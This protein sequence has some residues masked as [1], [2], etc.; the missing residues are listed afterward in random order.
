[1]VLETVADFLARYEV[2]GGIVVGLSGGADSVCLVY[3]LKHLGCAVTAVHVN[4][5]IRGAEAQRDAEAARAFCQTID[6]PFVLCTADAPQVAKVQ[7]LTLEQAARA[8]RYEALSQVQKAKQAQYIAVAHNLNDQAETVLLRLARG[9]GLTGLT[10]MKPVRG[11]IL[12]PLLT[13]PRK[14][15]EAFCA[16]HA[17]SYVT[18]S[19]NADP[20]YA[21]NAVRSRVLPALDAIHPESAA[22]I[23]RCATLLATDADYLAHAARNAFDGIA[24]VQPQRVALSIPALKALHCALRGRVLRMAI[25]HSM[26]FTAPKVAAATM[27]ET[28][29]AAKT[30]TTAQTTVSLTM[31]SSPTDIAQV[32]IE[33]CY[34]LCDLQSGRILCLPGGIRV[35]KSGTELIF[36]HA[37]D[38][39]QAQTQPEMVWFSLG[40][41]QMG[42]QLL[43]ISKVDQMG[44]RL[45]ATEYLYL[46]D[47]RGVC[48]RHKQSGD[49]IT[50]LGAPG[51][52][53]LK[54]YLIDKK[55]PLQQRGQLV[56]VARGHEILAVLGVT[57]AQCAA[58]TDGCNDIY[59]LALLN[60]PI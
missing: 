37:H 55:I 11:Q 45:P 22:N 8:V 24:H 59:K 7:G 29:T 21:R 42:N 1:M 10:A 13:V 14:E 39:A 38:T 49:Y 19:T 5:G 50:P 4:H 16:Q 32:H 30:E 3:A 60:N 48:L 26:D 40:E 33:A 28:E 57:V 43:H 12:R 27:A 2:H 35:Q 31:D 17:L 52:K 6:V 44:P 47:I 54:K 58:V 56:V 15:I 20:A 34:T 41:M 18:D 36:F 23:A 9:S 46:P 51:R 25:A 53:L